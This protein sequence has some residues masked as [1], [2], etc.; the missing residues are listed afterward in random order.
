M[1]SW[2][3]GLHLNTWQPIDL[4]PISLNVI[5]L[6]DKGQ[7]SVVGSVQNWQHK[8]SDKDNW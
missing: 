1:W 6:Q 4:F 7:N 2:N 5:T 8:G 3:I